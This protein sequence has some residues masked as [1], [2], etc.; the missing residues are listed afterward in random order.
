MS[1]RVKSLD[2]VSVGDLIRVEFPEWEQEA[3][4]FVVAHKRDSSSPS[5]YRVVSE[6]GSFGAYETTIRNGR[7]IVTILVPAPPQPLKV[8]DSLKDAVL[9]QVAALPV[10][11]V[12]QDGKGKAAWHGIKTQDGNFNSTSFSG[13]KTKAWPPQEIAGNRFMVVAFIPE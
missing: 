4:E 8:G 2:Q 10:G 12:V 7:Q 11:T 9:E 3:I 1:K 6:S 13:A 5:S